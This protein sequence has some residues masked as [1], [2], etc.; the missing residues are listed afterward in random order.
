M[1][2]LLLLL[3]WACSGDPTGPGSGK[4]G[5]PEVEKTNTTKVY[6]HYMPWFE[7][8]PFSGYWGTH[9]TM[10]NRNPDNILQNGQREIASHYYPLIGPY[11]SQDPAVIE[12][13]LLL[14]KYAGI[15]GVLVDW[16]GTHRLND[17]FTNLANS[18]AFIER[19]GEVGLDFGI[20]YE[21]FTAGN[22]GRQQ[23]QS[24]IEAAQKDIG[25][26]ESK[27][28]SSDNYIN[29]EGNPLLLTFGPRHFTSESDWNEVLSAF[30]KDPVFMP[31]WGHENLVG[32]GAD[33]TFSWVDFNESL[34]ELASFYSNGPEGE[35]QIGSAYPGFHDYY[36]EG[37]W[38]NSYG[39]VDL[40]DGQ[41]LR[42]TLQKAEEH[43]VDYLQLVTWNDFGEGTM[44]EPT[45]E[46]EF[47]FLEIIQEYTGVAYGRA[48]LELVYEYYQARK[49]FG[50]DKPEEI[51]LIFDALVTLET[52]KAA[53]LLGEL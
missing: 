9:W 26:I 27:Y 35:F 40:E 19:T 29:V 22:V 21:E 53:R 49:E 17:Y 48:E 13:H 30:E 33:G 38:G 1:S 15:D 16:Y 39:Y 43:S 8:K 42:N 3:L 47:L 41:T 44:I 32:E 5:I 25:Y 51:A 20:V 4:N 6:M 24:D 23:S 36:V 18:N 7:S 14:M 45:V 50:E 52:E 31:L 46:F 37:D 11:D 12:Y 34:S 10:A 2:L 28:F